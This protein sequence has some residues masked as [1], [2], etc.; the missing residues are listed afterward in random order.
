[1]NVDASSVNMMYVWCYE[2]SR[3]SECVQCVSVSL[4]R[5]S[6]VDIE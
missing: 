4:L 2:V 6:P 1:M 3:E 5:D